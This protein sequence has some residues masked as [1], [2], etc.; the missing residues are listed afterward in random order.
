MRYEETTTIIDFDIKTF[1]SIFVIFNF[2]VFTYALKNIWR[3]KKTTTI[4]YQ[5]DHITCKYIT[6]RLL[7]LR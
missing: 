6:S 1:L 4:K 3:I 7:L 5:G 2:V